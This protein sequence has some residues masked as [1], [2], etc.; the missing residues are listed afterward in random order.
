M[1]DDSKRPEVPAAKDTKAG[2]PR[3]DRDTGAALRS[4]YQ[5]TVD[6]K[7]PDELAD[8]LGKLA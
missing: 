1:P 7:V 6:E 4:I 8:L 3:G 2:A 5:S